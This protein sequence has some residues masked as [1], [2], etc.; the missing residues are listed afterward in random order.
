M[1][2]HVRG[3]FEEGKGALTVV[4]QFVFVQ[5]A[6]VTLVHDVCN[7][8]TSDFEAELLASLEQFIPKGFVEFLASQIVVWCKSCGKQSLTIVA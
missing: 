8:N 5:Y 3:G 2:E 1:L 7:P 6:A 4:S